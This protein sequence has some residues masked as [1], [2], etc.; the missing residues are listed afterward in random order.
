MVLVCKIRFARYD[1]GYG[2][3]LTQ[4]SGTANV[5]IDVIQKIVDNLEVHIKYTRRNPAA[6]LRLQG[7]VAAVGGKDSGKWQKGTKKLT[8]GAVL[9]DNLTKTHAKLCTLFLYFPLR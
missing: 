4:V 7:R 8:L 2:A 6:F 9:L 1:V 3:G 5:S